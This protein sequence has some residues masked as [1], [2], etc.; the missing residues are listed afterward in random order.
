MGTSVV[1]ATTTT[2]T[3]PDPLSGV[4]FSVSFTVPAGTLHPSGATITFSE[5]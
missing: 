5:P 4:K 2:W 1:L 3:C